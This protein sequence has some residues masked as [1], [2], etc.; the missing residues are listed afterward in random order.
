L[1]LMTSSNLLGCSIGR[2]PGLVPLTRVALM[3][4]SRLHGGA[5]KAALL[6]ESAAPR[7]AAASSRVPRRRM[8]PHIPRLAVPVL[9]EAPDEGRQVREM[10][11]RDLDGGRQMLRQYVWMVPGG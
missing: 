1:R 6:S 11:E 7:S 4:H 2:S 8:R 9:R 3:G 10:P 5:Q